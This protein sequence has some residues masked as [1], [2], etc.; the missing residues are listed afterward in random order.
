[1]AVLQQL[2]DLG[3]RIEALLAS[4]DAEDAKTLLSW[5]E[6]G[7]LLSLHKG[8]IEELKVQTKVEVPVYTLPSY[9]PD[10]PTAHTVT[11]LT[12]KIKAPLMVLKYG[13]SP[14]YGE[15]NAYIA[16]RLGFP[17]EAVLS[18]HF[19][20]NSE[21]FEQED[22]YSVDIEEQYDLDIDGY[23]SDVYVAYGDTFKSFL[24][25]LKATRPGLTKVV[26]RGNV[27]DPDTEMLTYLAQF[28]KPWLVVR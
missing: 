7:G 26:V 14:T 9:K 8:F 25:G 28:E 23:G 16:E 27:V 12:P 17:Q 15:I 10:D 2:V 22:T 19:F 11:V 6:A 1:M 21:T 4:K 3:K 18:T 5:G 13:G 20:F 24:E